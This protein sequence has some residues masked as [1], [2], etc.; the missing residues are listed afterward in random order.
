MQDPI[1]E[2]RLPFDCEENTSEE[3]KW[4][5]ANYKF[6]QRGMS[7]IKLNGKKT[8]V[9]HVTAAAPAPEDE[10]DILAS[11]GLVEH[12]VPPPLPHLINDPFTCFVQELIARILYGPNIPKDEPNRAIDG[13][14]LYND[15]ILYHHAVV[16]SQKFKNDYL[17]PHVKKL[18]DWIG[19]KIDDKESIVAQFF[20]QML[21]CK[22]IAVD[23]IEGPYT[24]ENV[25]TGKPFGKNDTVC[26]VTLFQQKHP[27]DIRVTENVASFLK[28]VHNVYHLE[29][30]VIACVHEHLAPADIQKETFVDSWAA[31]APKDHET[32]PISEWPRDSFFEFIDTI[33][34][35]HDVWLQSYGIFQP[36]KK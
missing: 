35:L 25:W 16:G 28:S 8:K 13:D 18:A 20:N 27:I 15:K 7:G 6:K 3:E 26:I 22:E 5:R 21:M 4:A 33:T 10:D 29:D 1:V 34:A 19:T 36:K 30:Y 2:K 32:L 31:V 12:H 11:L 17:I 9:E 14:K 24:F 23:V